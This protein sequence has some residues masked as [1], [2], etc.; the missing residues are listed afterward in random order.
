MVGTLE[1]EV[2]IELAPTVHNSFL[3]PF[4]TLG[5]VQHRVPKTGP[6]IFKPTNKSAIKCVPAGGYDPCKQA[7][8]MLIKCLRVKT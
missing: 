8:L 4:V 1:K 2:G 3:F 6:G 7:L 5:S